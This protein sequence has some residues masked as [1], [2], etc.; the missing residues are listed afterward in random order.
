MK[1]IIGVRNVAREVMVDVEMSAEDFSAAVKHA[2]AHGEVLDLTD[3]H[4]QNFLIPGSAI[5]FTQITAEEPR[6]VGFAL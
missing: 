2:V 1:V 6:R 3:S 5:G 4:G